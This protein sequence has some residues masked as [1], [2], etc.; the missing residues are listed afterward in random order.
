M[1]PTI[2]I[3]LRRLRHVEY[4]ALFSRGDFASSFGADDAASGASLT[5]SSSTSPVTPLSPARRASGAAVGAGISSKT[6]FGHFFPNERTCCRLELLLES[7]EQQQSHRQPRLIYRSEPVAPSR[8]PR[9]APLSADVRNLVGSNVDRVIVR[10]VAE[11][12]LPDY[13][14][15]HHQGAAGFTAFG[16][17]EVKNESIA[18]ASASDFLNTMHFTT[19]AAVERYFAADEDDDDRSDASGDGGRQ[20]LSNMSFTAT[21]GAATGDGRHRRIMAEIPVRFSRMVWVAEQFHEAADQLRDRGSPSSTNDASSAAA[22]KPAHH[23]RSP[24]TPS[25]VNSLASSSSIL[26]SGRRRTQQQPQTMECL[27]VCSDGVFRARQDEDDDEETEQQVHVRLPAAITAAASPAALAAAALGSPPASAAPSF[28]ESLRRV[29]TPAT[30]ASPAADGWDVVT[31][32]SHAPATT[33][34]EPEKVEQSTIK[35]LITS[36]LTM[37]YAEVVLRRRAFLEKQRLVESMRAQLRRK[38]IVRTKQVDGGAAAAAPRDE[39][40]VTLSASPSVP[41][42]SPLN[43]IISPTLATVASPVVAASSEEVSSSPAA[44]DD[45]AAQPPKSAP[46]V[47]EPEKHDAASSAQQ[48]AEAEATQPAPAATSEPP[49][50]E[51]RSTTFTGSSSGGISSQRLESFFR[52]KEI[53]QVSLRQELTRNYRQVE[54]DDLRRQI[55]ASRA[56]LLH[57]QAVADML[58]EQQRSRR[59][60]IEVRRRELE[61]RRLVV[62]ELKATSSNDRDNACVLEKQ[63][64]L[65]RVKILSGLKTI[66]PISERPPHTIC[67]FNIPQNEPQSEVHACALGCIVH[68]VATFCA[69]HGHPPLH[70]LL[71]HTSR[72]CVAEFVGAP[73]EKV[74]P[75]YSTNAQERDKSVR[76]VLLLRRVIAHA[77]FQVNNQRQAS[78]LPFGVALQMLLFNRRDK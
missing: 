64:R 51:S 29:G 52:R 78:D 41:L 28:A 22:G 12:L 55:E 18:A 77:A 10:I 47:A 2:P 15:H 45:D 75:L 56:Q 58:Q 74:F 69:V 36:T 72:S 31:R 21:T 33:N 48:Q 14:R 8:H 44:V 13:I 49:P 17:G 53:E 43:T 60:S 16:G 61:A 50:A 4:F 3:A 9:F 30:P 23:Q 32:A 6:S 35:A 67:G 76:A 5:S 42:E 65:C 27:V 11:E 24:S 59:A 57:Q 25:D 68:A 54:L 1:E 20:Q 37:H 73:A 70:P 19:T 40:S 26:A 34:H 63:L 66:F 62:V 71:S 7:D 38:T 46:A 39:S